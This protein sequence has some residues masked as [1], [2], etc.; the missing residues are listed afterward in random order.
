MEIGKD[1]CSTFPFGHPFTLWAIS[2]ETSSHQRENREFLVIHLVLDSVSLLECKT[3][4]DYS[5][6]RWLAQ[7]PSVL[8]EDNNKKQDWAILEG[9]TCEINLLNVYPSS[10]ILRWCSR[11]NS[12][13]LR[14]QFITRLAQTFKTHQR[15]V[16]RFHCAYLF[17]WNLIRD[18][19]R[20]GRGSLSFN[21]RL[22]SSV[23]ARRIGMLYPWRATTN[24]LWAVIHHEL[25]LSYHLSLRSI[26]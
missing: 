13:F 10:A 20:Y 26:V 16:D 19:A 17:C 11:E 7:W 9:W 8:D 3:R 4:I 21:E 18:D 14:F 23:V 22:Y 12:L 6:W 25:S 2:R 1:E 5:Q 24:V 15:C